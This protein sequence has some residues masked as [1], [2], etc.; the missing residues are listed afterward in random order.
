MSESAELK[1][2]RVSEC[3]CGVY[4]FIG[5]RS[6][7]RELYWQ[8]SCPNERK[9]RAESDARQRMPLRCV[10]VYRCQVRKERAL[11]ATELPK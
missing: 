8:Q 10:Y 11:L 5:A 6:E 7:K 9:R 3:R 1:A 4:M 2:M